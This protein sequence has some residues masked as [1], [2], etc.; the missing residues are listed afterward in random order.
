MNFQL[1]LAAR[2]LWGRKLRSFLTT[3]AIV[4]G[5]MVIFGMGI[6]LPTMTNAF[7][8]G[9]LSLSGAVDVTITQKTGE[10]FPA[11]TLN[12]IKQI[13]GISA[14]AGS[15]SRPINLP[16]NFY[17][18]NSN[19]TGLTITGI[20]P[21]VAPVLH[22]YTLTQ[23]RFLK[24]GDGLAAVVSTNL[25]DS[26]GLKLGDTLRIPTTEGAARLTI[27][28]LRPSH[29]SFGNEEVLITLT[30]AQK[31][32]DMSGLVNVIEA[33]LA[34]KDTAAREA[35]VQQIQA[36][37][38][39]SY[40]LNA[41]TSESTIMGAMQ[42]AAVA[43]NLL[44]YLTLFMGGFIIF[45]TFRTIVAERRHDIGM[46]RAIGASRG[47]IIGLI[48]SEGLVQGIVGTAIGL[49]IGYLL[50][51][52]LTALMSPLMQ[53]FLSVRIGGPVIEAGPVVAAIVLG[54][55]VTLFAG[56]LPALSAS[57]VTPI[58]VLRPAVGEAAQ[59]ISR[60]ATGVGVVMIV[61][62]LLGLLSG[63]FNLVALGGIL[64]LVGLVLIAPALVKPF[65][66]VFS[67]LLSMIFAREGTGGLAQGNIS[68]QP[69]RSA[70]T[71]SATM[72]GL[73]IIVG[74]GGL[75]YSVTGSV[76]GML[77]RSMNS[78]YLLVPPSVALWN[79]DL[80]ASQSLSNKIHSVS[81]IGTVS[82]LRYAQSEV[83]ASAALGGGDVQVSVLGIDPAAF[84]QVSGM[85]FQKGDPQQAYAALNEGRTI[86]VNGILAAQAGINLGDTIT[87]STP[88]G[89]Q[90]YRV[91][92]I[93]GDVMSMKI[94][95]A[96]IS[97]ANMRADFNKTEDIFYQID[98]APGADRAAADE[99]LKTIAA[100]YPQF[101]LVK[102]S[103]Y[104]AEFSQQYDAIFAGMYVLLGVL[105]LPS[106]IAIL[107]TL[108]IG[109]IERTREIGMLRAIGAERRQ[110]RRMIIAEALLLAAIGT[111]F[112]L[113]AGLYLGYVF[114]Q[115]L[116]ASGIYK[117]QYTFPLA[118]L[119]AATAAGLIFGVLASLF[120][121]RQ[122]SGMEI[123]Q[124][125][126]YE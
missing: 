61:V 40:T 45:N 70:I 88:R 1:T 117:M 60:L 11:S 68:R 84:T 30:E 77:Q 34:T 74:A 4:M 42:I 95:T 102:T 39:R 18:R 31:L 78:D 118:A 91:V 38:G 25:A 72:I 26:L 27:V 58:E 23:G 12:K 29:V 75:M 126:R 106:L 79:G 17:G 73:A 114:V 2:Y 109:V 121:A 66:N 108:A 83:P 92:A 13:D 46:L 124:A 32:L 107:N 105:S 37:L 87:L 5:V 22:D 94:N 49:V 6:L 119:L 43:F 57:R 112:G 103:Q 71:A 20:D 50:G 62:A 64:F 67:M 125:L 122:A 14:I 111:A 28:G 86:I 101:R 33:N 51:A 53:Q 120:P 15:I 44:G 80:G 85:D 104:L 55:G 35:I 81:G 123:I 47:T 76:V 116:N 69:S 8:Q 99:R 48:L 52:G 7:Q 113:I 21:A 89:Q 10:A 90:A 54:V 110:V 96:Y 97:Q 3:L 65:A 36:Q 100:D 82:T 98:L 41:L 16:S 19:V 56:L 24:P 93:G 115:G 63:S 9:I 59:R